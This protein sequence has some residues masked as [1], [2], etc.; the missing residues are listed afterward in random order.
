LCGAVIGIVGQANDRGDGQAI[1]LHQADGYLPADK[2]RVLTQWTVAAADAVAQAAWGWAL[3][4]D[5]EADRH[6][7]P[8]AR[9]VSVVSERGHRFRGRRTALIE[10][11]AWLDRPEPNRK[12]LVVM[13]S[14]G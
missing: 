13:G 1:T 8:R 5:K 6:W 11:A 12:V 10:V 7:R 3:G 14:P 9:G 2:I 4:G